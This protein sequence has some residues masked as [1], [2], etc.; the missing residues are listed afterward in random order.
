MRVLALLLLV[1]LLAGCSA[2]SLPFG[3]NETTVA[4][5]PRER[6]V[7]PQAAVALINEVRKTRGRQPLAADPRLSAI[8]Q[9]TARELA[10]RDRLKTELHTKRGLKRRLEEADYEAKRVAENLSAGSPTLALTVEGWRQSR[11]HRGNL[12]SRGFTRA[13]IG[14]ALTEEG[15]FKSY[16]VLI[17][18][19]PQE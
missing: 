10:E 9:E 5:V 2:V 11:R 4:N 8:A 7:D 15:D 6:Q 17:L 16:W 1:A 13:G 12:L 19:E 18:A 3:S 14:L